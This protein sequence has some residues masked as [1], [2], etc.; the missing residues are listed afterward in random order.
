MAQITLTVVRYTAGRDGVIYAWNLDLRNAHGVHRDSYQSRGYSPDKTTYRKH[1]QAHTHWINDL[2]MAQ[3]NAVL[4]SAS[5]DTSVKVWRPHT[6]GANLPETIGLHSDYVK[7]L[8]SPSGHSSWVAAGGLDRKICLWDLRGAG[9]RLLIDMSDEESGTKGSVYALGANESLIVSGGPECTVKI[10]DPKSARRVTNFVGHTD[11]IRSVLISQDNS[12]IMTASSD[13]TIKVWSMVAGRC[14]HTLTMHNDS[15]WCLESDHPQLSV[16]YSGDRS[17]VVAKTDTRGTGDLDDGLSVAICQEHAGVIKVIGINDSVWTATSS[18]S[19][20]RWADADTSA[21]VQMPENMKSFHGSE[22]SRTKSS[23][24]AYSSSPSSAFNAVP[25]P[26]IPLNCVLRISNTANFPPLRTQS[27][28]FSLANARIASKAMLLPEIAEFVPF[29]R[30]PVETIE[31]Q[32]GLIKHI[33]LNDK[34]RVLTL[35][36]AGVVTMW[37]LLRVCRNKSFQLW[38]FG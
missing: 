3:T 27:R 26:K 23:F 35:D 16:F 15:I 34:R 5:S 9:Q 2:V 12:M 24:S 33:L 28:T 21:G 32:H 7:C 6:E 4:V 31:G 20:N 13:Q 10:W 25:R 1:V 30:L 8:A 19:I 17:G 11:N 18:S 14:L 36:T 38:A 29:G 37:D 22:A